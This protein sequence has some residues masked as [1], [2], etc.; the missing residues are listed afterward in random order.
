MNGNKCVLCAVCVRFISAIAL[1]ALVRATHR[2]TTLISASQRFGSLQAKLILNDIFYFFFHTF[3]FE[4]RLE[5][6][7]RFDYE[8]ERKQQWKW[9]FQLRFVIARFDVRCL[10]S[11]FCNN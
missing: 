7:L 9:I 5:S 1:I 2:D 3:T 11:Q 10:R 4:F 6:C 8:H